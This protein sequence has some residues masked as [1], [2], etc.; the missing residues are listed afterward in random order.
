[1]HMKTIKKMAL[2]LRVCIGVSLLHPMV[3]EAADFS[4]TIKEKGTGVA[5]EGATVVLVDSEDYDT[6]SLKG[7]VKF[8]DVD[9]SKTIK[10]IATGYETEEFPIEQDNK[11][12]VL[13]VSPVSFEGDGLEV[14]AD[15]LDEKISKVRLS[16]AELIDAAGSG[17]DPLRAISALPG[18][19]SS[20]EE[21]AEVYMRGS[22]SRDNEF[23]VNGVPVGY[24]YHFGGLWSTINPSLIEDMN[25][26]LGGFPVEYGDALGGVIDTKLRAPRNDRMHYKFDLSTISGAFLVEGPVPGTGVAGEDSDSFYISGRRSYF[27][28]LLS[29]NTNPCIVN[30]FS[31]HDINLAV[32]CI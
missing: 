4:V 13:Y 21:T 20:G 16:K 28:L 11:Q 23:L 15:R 5:V 3:V 29:G 12:F 24:L 10:V 1:M 30:V 32:H 7:L 8:S 18:V 17:G 27:D 31:N 2:C 9:I 14:V 25:V 6:S 19:V 22:D 26:F